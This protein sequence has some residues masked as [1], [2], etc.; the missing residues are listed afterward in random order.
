[1]TGIGWAA[2]AGTVVA[3]ALMAAGTRS[4]PWAQP[5]AGAHRVPAVAG[6]ATPAEPSV[7]AYTAYRAAPAPVIDG[8]LDDAAWKAV[9]WTEDFVDIVGPERPK[10]RFRTRAKML[11]DDRYLYVG[12][13]LEEP[14]LWATLRQHDDTVWHDDDFEVFLDPDGDGLRYFEMEIN[15]LGTVLDLF[16]P[17]PYREGGKGDLAWEMKGLRSAVALHGTLNDASDRDR[18]WSVELAIPWTALVPPG[19]SGSGPPRSAATGPLGRPP[20]PHDTWRINFSRVEWRV[21]TVDGTYRKE[22]RRPATRH[23][24]DNWVW[25]PQ[26]EVDM[27][28]P[29]RWGRV[30]F[31]GGTRR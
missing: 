27:H 1:M 11:W 12:A 23:P 21:R 30:T 20:S 18:G 13:D 28:I 29:S 10:P 25:S 6:P 9:P 2:A 7:H 14:D 15:A 31:E 22:P 24:E 16:L 19:R 4:A 3:A 26:G 8:T 17:R 5:P